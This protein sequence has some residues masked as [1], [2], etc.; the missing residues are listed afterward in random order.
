MKYDRRTCAITTII[1]ALFLPGPGLAQTYEL[2]ANGGG[3]VN[4]GICIATF[5][6]DLKIK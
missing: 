6:G 5:E 1:A 4:G 2:P 3:T